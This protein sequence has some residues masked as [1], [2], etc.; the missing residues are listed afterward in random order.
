MERRKRNAYAPYPALP[1]YWRT[2]T[3]AELY[4]VE[5][6]D[7]QLAGFKFKLTRKADQAP[8]S[9][10]ANYPGASYAGVNWDNYLGFVL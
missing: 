4:Y 5:D 6:T 8:G 2:Y 10:V 3:G 1:Y 9:W 7:G